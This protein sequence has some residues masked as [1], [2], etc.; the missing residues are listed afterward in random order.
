MIAYIDSHKDR[1][2]VDGVRY[3]VEPICTELQV[4]PSTYYAARAR[5]PSARAVADEALKVEVERIYDENYKVYG[6]RKVWKQATREGL[7]VGRDRV[8]RLM[9]QLGLAGVRRGKVKRTTI[10]DPRAERAPDLV[11]R[12]F[13]AERPNQ[14]WVADFT[15]VASWAHTVYVAFVID[16]YSRFIVGWRA[17]T[18]MRT[19]LVLDALEMSIWRRDHEILDGLICHSDAG[20][21]YTSITY[22]ERL[23]E[24]GAAPSIG[25]VGDSYDNALAESVIGLF[26]TEL[27]R[28]HGPWRNVEDIELA[29]LGYVDWFNYRR[30]HTEI[31]DIP[32]AELEAAYRDGDIVSH[33][34][35]AATGATALTNSL[36]SNVSATLELDKNHRTG[37]RF[38]HNLTT[39][40]DKTS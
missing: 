16:V 26:K 17:A 39:T 24:I 14:L 9:R 3:G 29:T 23:D 40:E 18:T 19:E 27:I 7:A 30:L 12:R 8:A 35:A 25:S 37:P 5:P 21:Q 15:Y 1:R 34:I 33:T 11:E 6:Q 22:T 4:A 28:R 13:V 2:T 10:A 31:G 38:P 20:S 32:P 36:R